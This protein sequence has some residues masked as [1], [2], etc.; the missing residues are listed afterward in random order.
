MLVALVA[1]AWVAAGAEWMIPLA[2]ALPLFA[3]E[4]AFDARS[5]S[6][7][8]LPELCGAVGIAAVAASIVLADG[9]SARLAVALWLILAA[10]AVASVTFA[11]TQVLRL[12]HRETS[13][14]TSDL[15]QVAGIAIAIVACGVD[16]LVVAGAV[17]VGAVVITQFAWSRGRARP[18]KVV[19]IWQMVFGL[20]VVTGTAI[21]VLA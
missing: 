14:S 11:R 20:V 9:Q 3:V 7:R 17:C 12:R 6:R 8:L 2:V 10:R 15:A 19:G 16:T 21:G 4:L 13:T 5:R 18:A 1:T